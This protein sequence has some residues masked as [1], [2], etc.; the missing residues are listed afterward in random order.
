MTRHRRAF[1]LVEVI[2][3]FSILAGIALIYLVFVRS[4]SKELQFSADHL[5]AVVLSQKVAEDLIEEL[6][7]NPYGFETLGIEG[8]PGE[9][10]VVDG[11]SVFFSFVED[12]RAPFGKIDVN[13][14]GAI[15]PQMQPLYETVEKFKFKVAGRRLAT[16]GDHE[17]RNLMQGKIDFL[18]NASTGRGEFNTSMQ[19]F[20][21]VTCK[22]IDLGMVI[23]QD[24]VDAR[25]P[26]QVF[27]RPSQTIAEIAA[28][29]GENVETLQALGR[30][31]LVTRDFAG[32]EFYVRRKNQVRQLKL[33]LS[34]TPAADY[35]GQFE[36]RKGIAET[37]YEI[38]QICFQLVAYLEPQFAVLQI[39]GKFKKAIG[40][41]LN[42]VTFQQNLFYY[43]IIYE[44]FAGSLLQ[45]RY[46]YNGLLTGNLTRYKGGKVQTQ[47]IAKLVD[48]YRVIAILP[49]RPGGMQEY[50][51]FLSRIRTLSEGRNPYLSRFAVFERGLL[52]K[53]D[54]WLKRYPNLDR[55]HKIIVARIP[56]ILD[57]IKV[58]TVSMLS[59]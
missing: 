37:W 1:T 38:A 57:F 9:Q 43:R 58:Q 39:Q 30:I 34:N 50:R 48:L 8:S 2:I 17:D 13:S 41:G 26:A 6:S 35:D 44:Y 3:G 53:P 25:I 52:D 5:N 16:S 42:P 45:S 46:Y 49:T 12:T 23:D 15:G 32:S 59:Q 7:I 4:S 47:L 55:L 20:S 40:A 22:K 21:P 29:T 54:E 27:G 31:A 18:W 11:R 56:A 51:T 24:A 10:E 14:D 36:L 19:L 28:S 33:R